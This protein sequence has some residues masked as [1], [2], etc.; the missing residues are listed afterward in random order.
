M[1][2]S[3]TLLRDQV[4]QLH[5]ANE[6]ATKRKERKKKIIQKGG[7]LTIAEGQDIIAQMDV[8]R[9]LRGEM[10][11]RRAAAGASGQAPRS[12]TRCRETGHN[13][14]TCKKDAGD[15]N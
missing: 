10:R 11:Q 5:R 3:S 7:T 8:N 4:T 2:H 6:A 15:V 14:R 13:S 9:Q 1:A 12:C